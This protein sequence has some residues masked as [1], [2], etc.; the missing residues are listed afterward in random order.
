MK[1]SSHRA[2][3]LQSASAKTRHDQSLSDMRRSPQ[4]ERVG[5]QAAVAKDLALGV[6]CFRQGRF[7]EAEG[8]LRGVLARAPQ[9]AEA[10]LILGLLAARSGRMPEAESLLRR[11]VRADPR[12]PDAH[13]NL[14]NVL[15]ASGRLNE[16]RN[17]Y[18][19]AARLVPHNPLP[20][21]NLANVLRTLGHLDQ[22]EAAYRQALVLAPDYVDARI[23]LGNLLAELGADEEAE[24]LAL[25]VLHE[26]PERYEV[27][28]NLGNIYG[29]RGRID[30]ARVQYERLLTVHPGHP[31]ALLSLATVA[32][33]EADLSAAEGLIAQA[34]G[35]A[36]VPGH[37]VM[38]TLAMNYRA[39]RDLAAALEA[40]RQAYR[41]S[42]GYQQALALA[43]LLGLTGQLTEGVRLLE[44]GLARYGGRA[45][46]LLSLLFGQQSAL[47]DWRHWSERVPALVERIRSSR[48][49]II[50]PFLAQS[51]PGLTASDLQRVARH[52]ARRFIPWVE[53]GPLWRTG[54]R[55]FHPDQRI[56][57][58]YLSAD[59]RDHP[60]A[61]LSAGVF[62]LHDRDRFEV[63]AYAIGP[64]D[65]GPMR[66]RLQATFDH[67]ANLNGL[68]HEDAARRI[69]ADGID[70]LVDLGGYTRHAR[71]EILALRPAPVQ[72]TWLGFPGTLG[73]PFIDYQ[74][75]DP[76]V[77][78]LAQAAYHDEA[79]AYLPHCYL[80]LDHQRVLAQPPG[81]TEEGLPEEGL[82]FASF[83]R[84]E[85]VTPEI[86]RRW[87]E[88][89]TA[90]PGSVLWLLIKDETTRANLVRAARLAHL[91]PGRL[92]FGVSRPQGEHLAR[93]RLAD[94][95]LDTM[96][97]GGHTTTADAL[98]V[99]VPV[100]TCLGE[101]WPSRVAASLLQAAA[102]P[103]LIAKDLD[104]YVKRAINLGTYPDALNSLRRR[105]ADAR[106]AAPLFDANGFVH[107]LESLFG[108]MWSRHQAGITPQVLKC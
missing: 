4:E 1:K 101:T 63:F 9:T 104:D 50:D 17:H 52:H 78:P 28:L 40:G 12:H 94:L 99:G 47:C 96:P 7:A 56:R 8:C 27:R 37:E 55:R 106:Q 5:N 108:Q 81:R 30:L 43:E 22:A 19:R 26:H 103:D 24:T 67:F 41:L 46:R 75:A 36:D 58:G 54:D 107:A 83:N 35:N 88:I 39:R 97:Y 13:N 53:R 95:I 32:I 71:P 90:V 14:G 20:H 85:K 15:L 105:L 18:A 25:A 79:L 84:P 73:A 6:Q 92:R 61:Y 69:L 100:L 87:T 57:L 70:I 38:T 2:I 74:I 49:A 65:E 102:M 72:V 10:L 89:L 93:I 23:N 62:A 31:R 68:S 82:V 34:Q 16:A 80:P 64:D 76:V 33:A 21:Y 86:F 66:R 48:Q 44:N 60:T 42:G 3:S 45:P 77:A 11:C 59:L 51:L 98:W 29:R 91:D